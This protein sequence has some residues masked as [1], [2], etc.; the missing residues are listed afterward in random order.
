MERSVK[1]DKEIGIGK[2]PQVRDIRVLLRADTHPVPSLREMLHKSGL[3]RRA[4]PYHHDLER[5]FIF[6]ALRLRLRA[7]DMRGRQ[8][9][10]QA[11]RAR[12]PSVPIIG[13][14]W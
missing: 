1:V 3:T 13:I 7:E 4:Y 6:L 14:A 11:Q 5:I 8:T 12:V 9:I 2:L 10:S